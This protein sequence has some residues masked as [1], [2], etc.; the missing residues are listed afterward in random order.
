MFVLKQLYESLIFAFQSFKV[1]KTRT[2]LSLLGITIGIFA[3]ISVFTGIDSLS[4]T[5]H[6]SVEKMGKNSAYISKWPWDPESESGGGEFQWWK[7]MNR[8]YLRYQEY[9]SLLSAMEKETEYSGIYVEFNR[10]IS[11]GKDYL[12]GITINGI[13]YEYDKLGKGLEIGNGRY[14]TPYEISAGQPAA[15]IGATIAEHL[16]EGENP[17]GKTM[18]IGNN[19]VVVIGVIK[20][21]GESLF[22]DSN[23]EKMYIPFH[24]S[25]QM[26]N[27][28]WSNPEIVM[29]C[30]SNVDFENYKSEIAMNLRKIRRLRPE[31]ENTFSVNE[32]SAIK[33]QMDGL[34]NML[35]LAGGIIGLFSIL[36]GGFG[37]ANIMFVSVKERTSQIGIMKALGAKRYTILAQF[38]FEAILLSLAGGLVGLFLIWIGTFIVSYFVDFE[39]ILTLGNIILGLVIASLVGAISGIFPAWNAARMEPVKAI[40]NSI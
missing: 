23:D 37:V 2:F 30:Y 11:R 21:E 16:F 25:T 6:K 15:I 13:T 36:V 3:I 39:L 9:L 28:N 32:I 18:K 17:V 4:Y 20:K 34:F 33:H 12:D 27:L 1:N 8:P 40:Y 24:F 19:K 10:A 31:E 22:G 38:V 14:F 29:K 35:T 5:L 26:I 7:Y